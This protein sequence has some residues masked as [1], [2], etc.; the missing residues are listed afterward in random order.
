MCAHSVSNR[1]LVL[2]ANQLIRLRVVGGSRR[3]GLAVDG[4]VLVDLADGD[5]VEVRRS[6]Q[7]FFLA[8]PT[9]RSFFD[10]L[11]TRL[12]WAGQPPYE[13]EGA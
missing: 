1:P 10:V 12:H 13:G 4:Q 6:A 7:P 2:G 3:P 9:G 8:M 5:E 11:R